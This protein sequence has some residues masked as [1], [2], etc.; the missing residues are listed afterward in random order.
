MNENSP[1]H[2]YQD[3]EIDLKDLLKKVIKVLERGTKAIFLSV[4]LGAVLGLGYFLNSGVSYQSSLVLSSDILKLANIEALFTPLEL[5]LDEGNTALVSQKLHIEEELAE[6]LIALEVK[7]VFENETLNQEPISYFEITAM[8]SDNAI[9]PELQ[10]GLIE[11]LTNNDYVKRRVAL[12]KEKLKV[13]I[14]NVDNEIKE[15]ELLKNRIE[16]GSVLNSGSSNVVLME[17]SNLYQQS[18]MMFEKKQA[19]IKELALVESIE[20]VKEFT[21]FSKPSSP[22]WILC[23]VMGFAGG[24]ILGFAI[25][26]FREMDRY[27]R[28]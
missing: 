4:L 21:P 16:S 7:S 27:V 25:L 10:Q 19:F 20:V 14:E 5:L 9:L 6:K 17:P 28:S 18:M 24:L 11:Y 12:D 8:V 15:I 23:L 3:D 2:H 26:F 13:L 1:V 22:S